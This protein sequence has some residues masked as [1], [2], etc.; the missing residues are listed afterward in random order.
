[1]KSLHRAGGD[2]TD[3]RPMIVYRGVRCAQHPINLQGATM[4]YVDIPTLPEFKALATVRGDACI[5]IYLPTTPLPQDT[6][7]SRA[8]LKTFG[9]TALDQLD[10]AGYDKRRQASIGE[11]LAELEEDGEFWRFQARSLAVLLTPETMRT[12]RLPNRLT[13][14][15]EVSDRFHLKP[16]LRAI[17]FPHEAFVLAL[18]ENAVRLVEVFADLPPQQVTVDELPKSAADAVRRAS[19]NDRSPSRR[20]QGLEGQKVLLRQYC[21]RIDVALR[22]VLA[23]RSTPLILAATEP[24][25]SIYRLVNTYPGY[26]QAAIATSPDRTSDADLAAAARPILDGIYAH[27]LESMRTLFENR[28]GQGRATSD[29]SDA[30]RAATFG[31]IEQLMVDIDEVIPGTVDEADGRV[32]FAEKLSAQTYG[33]VDEI[34][35]RALLSGASVLGVR[36]ED[37]PGR[38]SLAAILRYQI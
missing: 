23:G 22:S 10:A 29:L 5:S 30:A 26:V 18:S 24:L 2:P 6:I 36:K 19:V 3:H 15:V 35:V 13:A 27:E 4:L 1:M 12:F 33:I 16:L 9:R 31:A 14:M 17:T 28:R 7:V 21:R 32:T 34:A 8:Q 38:A 20:I 25:A 11:H 37:I